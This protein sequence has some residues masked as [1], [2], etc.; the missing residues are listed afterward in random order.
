MVKER[1]SYK[2]EKEGKEEEGRSH[3]DACEER[4]LGR[5]N[6]YATSEAWSVSAGRKRVL[7][8]VWVCRL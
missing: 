8:L 2:E 3:D 6:S 7:Y 1:L 5:Y 4:I